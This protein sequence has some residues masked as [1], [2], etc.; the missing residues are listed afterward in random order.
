MPS[1]HSYDFHRLP[2][3][4]KR[5][6]AKGIADGANHVREEGP[7]NTLFY[8]FRRLGLLLAGLVHFLWSP[9]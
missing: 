1:H 7:T 6:L 2:E 8:V 3:R 9:I 4:L 5:Q